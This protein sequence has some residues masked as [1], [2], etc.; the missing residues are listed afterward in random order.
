MGM[1]RPVAARREDPLVMVIDNEPI[2]LER[3]S[4]QVVQTCLKHMRAWVKLAVRTVMAE[5][6]SWDYWAS[7]RVFNGKA[8]H[9]KDADYTKDCQRLSMLAS[10]PRAGVFAEI[11][12]IE[13]LVGA[14]G[15][16]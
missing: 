1:L 16:Q 3:P 8:N 5:F 14:L 2:S 6:P 7:F 4:D 10:M 11:R 15:C 13:P 12:L 9:M